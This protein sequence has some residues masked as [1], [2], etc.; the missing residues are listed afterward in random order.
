MKSIMFGATAL[1]LSGTA[2]AASAPTV[3]TYGASTYSWT[4]TPQLNQAAWT[5][6][7]TYDEAAAWTAD[8]PMALTDARTVPAA[9]WHWPSAK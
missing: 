1:L 5:G 6:A 9:L 3:T 8:K 4:A 7:M 2:M